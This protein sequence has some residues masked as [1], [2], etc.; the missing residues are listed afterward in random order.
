M[1]VL[2][3]DEKFGAFDDV[4]RPKVI[5]RLNGQEVKLVK[6]KGEF[7][8]HAHEDVD[9]MFIGWKGEFKVQFRHHTAVIRPG[10]LIV[11]PRG[12]EHRTL[13]DEEAEALIFEPSETRKTGD[14]IDPYFTAPMGDE[15]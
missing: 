7:P 11:I 14:V 4:W 15:V 9:E 3:L 8:W 2:G 1:Q 12:V 5:A 10:E 6:M 13:A